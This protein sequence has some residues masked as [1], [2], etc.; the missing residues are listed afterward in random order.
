MA[1][2]T[3]NTSYFQGSTYTFAAPTLKFLAFG[4]LN[5]D[6]RP[7]FAG[8][9][10][11]V[12]QSVLSPLRI[13]LSNASGGF[14]TDA[15]IFSGEV[16]KFMAPRVIIR[17]FTG[18][19]INDLLAYDAGNYDWSVRLTLGR[20][21]VLYKG[22]A[23]GQLVA[24]TAL[25][26]ALKPLV[27]PAPANGYLGGIQTDLTLGIKD[28][29]AADIDGDGDMDLWVESTGSKNI[30]SH[31]MINQGGSFTVDL[32]NRLPKTVL[33]GPKVGAEDYWRYGIGR[34]HDVNGDGAPDLLLGQI[35]DNHFT[36][37][38][39]SSFV[40]L[41]NGSGYF[42]AE[43][44][45]RLPLPDFYHG[46][47]AVN[48]S[49]SWDMNGDGKNDLVL[50]HT[51]NDDVSGSDVETPW[52]GTYVQVL[53]QTGNAEFVDQ[54]AERMGNQAG[55][56]G[57]DLPQGA[58]PNAISHYDV[59]FDGI[60]DF[61]LTYNNGVRP[62]STAP[63][64]FLGKADGSFE[65]GDAA[66][67]TG[68]DAYFGEDIRPV[69]LNGDAYLD[70]VHLD[71]SPGADGKYD[72]TSGGDDQ[73]ILVVQ[74]GI[75]PLGAAVPAGTPGADSLHGGSFAD[76][77]SGLEGDDVL[78]GGDGN[79]SLT[80]GAGNDV[81]A[82]DKG[83]DLAVYNGARHEFTMTRTASGY[84]A[85][86]ASEGTDTLTGIERIKFSDAS[87][88]LG[89]GALAASIRTEDL[90]TLEEL[91]IAF[92]NRM[93]DADG[94][95]YW[96]GQFKAGSTINS[97]AESFYG[98]AVQYTA[99]TGYLGTM[100]ND[101]FVRVIYKN[102][103]GRSGATAPSNDDVSYWSGELAGGRTTKGG[104]VGTM[105]A[106][107]HSFKGNATWGWVPDLLDNKVAVANF[108]AVQHGLSYNTPEDSI[109]KGM[110]IAAAVTAT[111]TAD[112]LQLI[113]ITDT[114]FTV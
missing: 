15:Q 24:T 71:A 48:A 43:N 31:F 84:T 37:I 91:Y 79:D 90:K 100:S 6:K 45:R 17:D 21:P 107:A 110:A 109:T 85:S 39:Q 41:N 47:T 44:A 20:E 73:H 94:L 93:P 7:D 104:L 11:S 34:F 83:D 28:I 96:I 77:L 50:V 5:G 38:N 58:Y 56:S 89:V 23:D 81:I 95:A 61:L 68:G 60:T 113:G 36:H 78:K 80:G 111:G 108:F 101:D 42:P 87:V 35:R 10:V 32:D 3:G 88:N 63:V 26:D 19:G 22:T 82:G 65:A 75:S 112:A 9:T 66:L 30:T 106:S 67:L 8:I 25:T 74:H 105:L 40:V 86:S 103:L 57:K 1:V 18:D 33:F 29:D 55:W 102:V 98:A 52:T 51:R 76:T 46:Y 72:N 99:L 70:F 64:V 4:D 114:Q 13:A 69:D 53:I 14:T 92:F 2:A 27:V 54:T 59:N 49:A 12:D 16:P 97:I 62:S